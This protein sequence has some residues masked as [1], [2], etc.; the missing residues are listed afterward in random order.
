MWFMEPMPN[1]R[2]PSRH[3]VL[4]HFMRR[5]GYCISFLEEDCKTNL[6]LK[7]SFATPDK[8]FEIQ[9]R[10]GEIRTHEARQQI[11]R[12]IAM[13]RPGGVWLILSAEEYAKLKR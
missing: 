9:E 6:K 8:I 7:L 12:D 3:R 13:G 1:V 10:W 2:K 4:M 11:E 5:N